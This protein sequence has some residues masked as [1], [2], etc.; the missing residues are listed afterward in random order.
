MQESRI[1]MRS[2]RSKNLLDLVGDSD[3]WVRTTHMLCA[4]EN[5]KGQ[6]NDHTKLQ[7]NSVFIAS[8]NKT[9]RIP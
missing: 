5:K 3:R 1:M 2:C 7:K 4:R 9:A 6:S 8:I